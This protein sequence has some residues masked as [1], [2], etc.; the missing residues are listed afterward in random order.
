MKKI[1]L[2]LSLGGML[3]FAAC[4]K[5]SIVSPS[6]TKPADTTMVAGVSPYPVTFIAGGS[7]DNGSTYVDAKGNKA[8]FSSTPGGIFETKDGTLYLADCYNSA[9]RKIAPDGTVTTVKVPAALGL[10]VPSDVFISSK[11]SL[12]VIYIKQALPGFFLG[13]VDPKGNVSQMTFPYHKTTIFSDLEASKTD[14]DMFRAAVY[15]YFYRFTENSLAG[16]PI[17]IQQGSFRLDDYNYNDGPQISA[18]ATDQNSIKYFTGTYGK[19]IY[20]TD[21]SSNFKE[22]VKGHSFTNITSIAVLKD[23]SEIYVTDDGNL[24]KIIVLDNSVTT[25]VPKVEGSAPETKSGLK[26]MDSHIPLFAYADHLT[27]SHDGNYLYFTSVADFAT[28]VNKIKIH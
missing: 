7:Y 6:V 3:F 14:D 28:T 19:H 9:I 13:K 16:T 18:L 17:R 15:P 27:L 24:K 26:V 2:L 4:K 12:Y 22:I 5:E 1:F 10:Y 20:T 8:R 25:L 11:G 21:T 23:G